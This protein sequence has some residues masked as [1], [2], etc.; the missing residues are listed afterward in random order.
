MKESRLFKIVY[1]LLEKDKLTASA[2][3]EELEVSI[4]TI[5]RDID[6]L[7]AAGIPIYTDVGRNGG[8]SLMD[9]FV[10]DKTIL[11]EKEKKEILS[12]LQSLSLVLPNQN[13]EA[14]NK[15]S[16]LFKI[17]SENWFELDFS[18]WGERKLDNVR[19]ETI[20]EAIIQNK[21]LSITYISSKGESLTRII[22]PLTLLFKSKEWYI[23]AY[24]TKAN[25]FRLFKF[26]RISQ[27]ILTSVNFIPQP[28]PEEK[29]SNLD[30]SLVVLQFDSSIAYRAYDEFDHEQITVQEDGS[31]IVKSHIPEDFWLIS[32]LL[33]LGSYV[34]VIEPKRLQKVL[35][36]EAN[37]I[38]QL[39]K[40]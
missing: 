6:S 15:L 12:S 28:Y 35:V 36:E 13:Q 1:R 24:C 5:Y 33:S 16:A 40:S 22:Q 19:F 11:S 34:R 29:P 30:I 2:L 18:R 9:E 14:L 26:T 10:L 17:N 32:H 8:I 3:A 31:V 25:D 27:C 23:K 39:N 37:K 4:R 20:K 21:E 7:S 38:I